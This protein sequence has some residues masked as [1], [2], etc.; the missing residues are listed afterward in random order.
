M[1]DNYFLLLAG[2]IGAMLAAFGVSYLFQDL[3]IGFFS[4]FAIALIYLFLFDKNMV[5]NLELPGAKT[6]IRVL[7]CSLVAVQ[8]FTA[9]I[10]YAKAER[11]KTLLS[12]IR[13]TIDSSVMQ[14]DMKNA[15]LV[16]FRHYHIEANRQEETLGA[17]FTRLH[18]DRI[19][20]DGRFITESLAQL[21]DAENPPILYLYEAVADTVSITAVAAISNGSDSE[22]SNLN[23]ETGKLQMRATLTRGGIDYEREN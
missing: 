22:F 16:T 14:S 21:D 13:Q 12:D 18:S 4:A 10:M 23:G 3:W 1:K 17:L 19:S 2:G 9:I 15:L 6:A 5:R 8:L 7:V 20:G 11:Q